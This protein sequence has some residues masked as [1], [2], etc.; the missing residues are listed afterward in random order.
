[1]FVDKI[2]LI[3]YEEMKFYIKIFVSEIWKFIIIRIYIYV[4]IYYF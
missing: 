3:V 2:N 4:L 1:M